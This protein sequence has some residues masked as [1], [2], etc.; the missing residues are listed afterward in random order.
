VGA[1]RKE[2]YERPSPNLTTRPSSPTGRETIPVANL[3][4]LLGK[5]RVM[6][7]KAKVS[8][9][10]AKMDK[11]VRRRE[12]PCILRSRSLYRERVVGGAVSMSME[13]KK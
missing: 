3:L 10:K 11:M 12:L 9:T 1:P 6:V 4:N 2:S 5:K 13:R 8:R 7:Q